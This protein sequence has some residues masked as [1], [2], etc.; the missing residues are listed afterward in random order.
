MVRKL[1]V[2]EVARRRT[3]LFGVLA[4]IFGILIFRNGVGFTKFSL[5]LLAIYFLVDGLGSFL[6]RFLL[7]SKSISYSH[8]I[9]FFLQEILCKKDR[10][11]KILNLS[12]FT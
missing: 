6:L 9:F 3:L 10:F 2:E 11:L 8:S 7:R 4:V 5:D 1:S 12:F